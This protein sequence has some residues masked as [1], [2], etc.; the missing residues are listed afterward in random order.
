MNTIKQLNYIFSRKQKFQFLILVMIILLGSL[1]ELVGVA[2]VMPLVDI[3]TNSNQIH[4]NTLYLKLYETLNIKSDLMFILFFIGALAVI[5]IV[6]NLYLLFMYDSQFR[7]TYNNKRRITLKLMRAYMYRTY[8]FHLSKNISELQRNMKEDIDSLF[9]TI[10]AVV[11]MT[12]ELLTCMLIA[13]YLIIIDRFITF[14]ILAVLIIFMLSFLKTTK[15]KSYEFGE[16]RRNTSA[17]IN[18]W[19]RQ[20]FEGIKEIIISNKQELFLNKVD[21]Q[22]E[23]LSTTVRRQEVVNVSPRPIFEA[24]TIT[25]LL[26]VVGLKIYFGGSVTKMIPVLS[27]FAVVAVRLLPSFGRLAG[28]FN[29]ITYNKAAILGVYRD[30]KEVENGRCIGKID[31][32]KIRRFEFDNTIEINDVYYTYPNC[33][34]SVI[35]GL[36]L[37]IEKDKSIAIIGASGSGKSTLADMLLGLLE[38]SKGNILVDGVNINQNYY[39]WHTL[40][41]YIPQ[42]IYILDDTIRNN[43]IFGEGDVDD[44]KVWKALENAQ[45]ADFIKN[46]D[47]GLDTVVGE[48]GIRLSGGQRQRIGIARALYTNPKILILDE[49]TS[50]LDNETETA[51]MEAI[52]KLKG[53]HTMIIIAHRLTTIRNC[54]EIYEIVDGKAIYRD[55]SEV[56]PD[57]VNMKEETK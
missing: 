36:S 12:S 19:T 52:E 48:R 15:R 26:V 33:D 53:S 23:I 39:G 55:K 6:K 50:A 45:L 1:F 4:N 3:L 51:V 47:D 30:L 54:D 25:S 32:D 56:L 14:G 21:K 11:Q 40:I 13:I 16:I 18:K 29:K 5:Y 24:I 35:N 27:A 43:V 9:E 8:E 34:N 49:A 46:L 28:Y 2:S 57:I 42:L 10:L 17:N 41:G 20:S 44:D 31:S 7:F 38:P 22:Q 37:L